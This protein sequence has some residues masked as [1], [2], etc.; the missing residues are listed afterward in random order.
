MPQANGRDPGEA[1]WM[2][3]SKL[4]FDANNPRIKHGPADQEKQLSQREII[5]ILWR[6]FAVDEVALSI[7]ANGYFPH[8]PLFATR[9]GTRLVVIEGNRRLAA[10]RILLSAELREEFGTDVLPKLT[11]TAQGRLQQVPVIEC[12]RA[13]VWQYIGFK[14]VNGPQA[15]QSYAKAQY[16]AW[17]RNTLGV[18]LEDIALQIGDTHMTVKRH[19][20]ALMAIEQSEK[21]GVFDRED[22][23]KKHFSFSHLYTGLDYRNFQ[24][25]TGIL[26]DASYAKRN[27][28]PKKMMKNFGELCLWLFGSKSRDVRP[29]VETQNPDL[30]VLDEVIGSKNGLAALRKGLPLKVSRDITE[31]DERLFRES[32][33]GAKQALQDARGRLLTGYEGETDL[34]ADAED[35]RDLATD[36][37]EEMKE[38]RRKKRR[39]RVAR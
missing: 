2:D 10:I 31:G 1:K 30:R 19:Y 37:H 22:R 7:A 9:E 13:G 14:H 25:F 28:V 27:P 21:V 35:I 23:W 26:S 32:L 8:E 18:S 20:R 12:E 36:L 29:L 11:K 24:N 6:E 39:R 4:H 3:Q 15:W 33:V 5:G 16:A 34:L 17:V 38:K